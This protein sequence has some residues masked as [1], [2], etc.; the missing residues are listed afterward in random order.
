[1]KKLSRILIA[2]AVAATL[3]GCT[4]AREMSYLLDLEKNVAY[5]APAAPEL[6]IQPG[7][8]LGISVSS[9]DARL[10]AP[11][12]PGT[13]EGS[14]YMVD[15]RGN[16]SFPVIGDM[17]VEGKTIG[18]VKSDIAGRI[19]GLGYIKE[20]VVNVALTNFSV[21]VI[22]NIGNSVL[23]VEGSSINLLQAIARSGGITPNS[24]IKDV[25][26]VRT[27]N[28][29]RTAYSVNLQ[30][31]ELFGSP[32]FYLRQNDIIYVQPKGSTLSSEGQVAMSFVGAG[33]SLASIVTSFLLWS[34]RQ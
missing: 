22:G 4:T 31:K 20:P 23:N 9:D 19:S 30:K 8:R 32:V 13:E 6:L 16:I 25:V 11:F 27:E 2:G 34:S 18:E 28:G 12:N 15:S 21:T 33:L 5:E 26:V 7:D 10:A 1:M 24:K 29:T 17:Q 3:A 14:S